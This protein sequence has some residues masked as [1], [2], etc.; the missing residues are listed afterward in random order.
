MASLACLPDSSITVKR[1]GGLLCFCESPTIGLEA[2]S[3]CRRDGLG[4]LSGIYLLAKPAAGVGMP[5]R[6]GKFDYQSQHGGKRN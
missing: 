4:L 3:E 1:G 2:M 5:S 6:P